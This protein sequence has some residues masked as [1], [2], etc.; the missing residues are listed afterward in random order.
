MPLST[1]KRLGIM[2]YK[3]CNLALLLADV[4][5]AHP[6]GLAQTED[7]TED[8]WYEMRK[9]FK[10]QSRVIEGFSSRVMKLKDQLWMF[11][12]RVNKFSTG[13]DPEK[14]ETTLPIKEDEDFTREWFA[15]EDQKGVHL[16][17]RSLE[18]ESLSEEEISIPTYSPG[19]PKPPTNPSAEEEQLI[20]DSFAEKLLELWIGYNAQE[21]TIGKSTHKME[22]LNSTIL[23]LQ[24]MVKG[25]HNF[26]IEDWSKEPG[27]EEEDYSTNQKEAY[28]EE[29][30]N[31]YSSYHMS[32]EDAEYDS[33]T[34][35]STTED[36]DFYVPLFNPF[37]D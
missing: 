32:R 25:Y 21:D 27:S 22:E 12:K 3:F 24:E 2:E 10:W 35:N 1:A 4:S 29:K 31:E 26:E 28:F 18:S 9:K 23:E 11:E 15:P 5:V 30:S 34:E 8:D 37:S 20:L 33:C 16:E 6:H 7:P 17:E 14:M 13:I 36:E 19:E